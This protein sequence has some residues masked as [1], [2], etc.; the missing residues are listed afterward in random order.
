[1]RKTNKTENNDYLFQQRKVF[2]PYVEM[3]R[4]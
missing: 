4:R 2:D 3:L 1:M